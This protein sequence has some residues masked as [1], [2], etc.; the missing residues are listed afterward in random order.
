MLHLV[1]MGQWVLYHGFWI[2]TQEFCIWFLDETKKLVPAENL[3]AGDEVL[4]TLCVVCLTNGL[5]MIKKTTPVA[6]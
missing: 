6:L 2:K 4:F 3:A 1:L 5:L